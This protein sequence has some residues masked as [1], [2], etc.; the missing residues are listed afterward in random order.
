MREVWSAAGY[1]LTDYT[2]ALRQAG[3]ALE[4]PL[5]DLCQN[6]RMSLIGRF[7]RIGEAVQRATVV[8]AAQ[9]ALGATIRQIGKLLYAHRF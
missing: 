2:L 7:S 3:L 1:H 8:G 9:V 5:A 4:T 6:D